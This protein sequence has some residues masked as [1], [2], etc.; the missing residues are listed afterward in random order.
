[1]TVKA[2]A[3]LKDAIEKCMEIATNSDAAN[4]FLT[5]LKK[6]FD[7]VGKSINPDA[8]LT[9]LSEFVDNVH[10]QRDLRADPWSG[11]VDIK[12]D[13]QNLQQNLAES[14]AKTI[15]SSVKD[16]IQM[17]FALSKQAD[18]LRAFSPTDKATAAALDRIFN[19]CLANEGMI[20]KG[21]VIYN[22]N[23]HGEIQKDEA[24]NPVRANAEKIKKLINEGLPKYLGEKGIKITTQEKDYPEKKPQVVTK[25]EVKAPAQPAVEVTSPEVTQEEVET[26]TTTAG[27]SRSGG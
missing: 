3:P 14:A 21:G 27:G 1:M 20:S 8:L 10:L 22:A 4:Y 16:G 18:F 7:K 6:A 19:Y 15:K 25:P 17:D 24:G 11:N 13:F 26:P 2:E 9:K 23:E 5:Q 12:T